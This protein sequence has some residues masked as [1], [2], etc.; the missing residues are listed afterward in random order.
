LS[1]ELGIVLVAEGVETSQ[2]LDAL[3]ALEAIDHVQGYLTGM[4]MSATEHELGATQLKQ[5]LELSGGKRLPKPRE[6]LQSAIGQ[7][8]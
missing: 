1:R 7:K 6:G 5:L 3:K 4:P 2:Q 8:N